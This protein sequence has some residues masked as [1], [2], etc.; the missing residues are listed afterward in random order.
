MTTPELTTL[1]LDLRTVGRTAVDL[2]D[3]LLS[4]LIEARSPAASLILQHELIVRR[5]A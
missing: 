1:S 2:L 4:G 3:G 5:S